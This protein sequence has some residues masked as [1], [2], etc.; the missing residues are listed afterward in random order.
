MK[1]KK[2]L[3]SDD[4]Y[5]EICAASEKA[6]T[7]FTQLGLC[8]SRKWFRDNGGTENTIR[9][10]VEHCLGDLS[11]KKK[12]EHVNCA[13]GGLKVEIGVG[14]FGKDEVDLEVSLIL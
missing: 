13:T 1:Y 14:Y 12:P 3:T 10:L 9:E 11:G 5:Q 2:T 6:D 8:Y 7:I 4:F